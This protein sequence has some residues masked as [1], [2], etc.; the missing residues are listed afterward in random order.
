MRFVIALGISGASLV[1]ETGF[2]LSP[3]PRI[4]LASLTH[5][6]L[7]A[8][9][10]TTAPWLRHQFLMSSLPQ[11]LTLHPLGSPSTSWALPEMGKSAPISSGRDWEGDTELVQLRVW[12]PALPL[13][14][15]KWRE[16]SWTSLNLKKNN[17]NLTR[18]LW[19]LKKI[20]SVKMFSTELPDMHTIS[21]PP[22]IQE[23]WSGKPIPSPVDLPNPGIKLGSRA[24]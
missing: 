2:S 13:R 16:S 14:A 3:H 22:M 8:L 5:S 9:P 4:Q 20:M 19:D 24:L 1:C 18:L 6:Q 11:G 23:H 7:E 17:A 21:I 10:W 15:M 12:I